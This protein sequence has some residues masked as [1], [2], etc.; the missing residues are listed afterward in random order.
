MKN[1]TTKNKTTETNDAQSALAELNA[2]IAELQSRRVTLAEPLK[3]RHAEMRT[4]LGD[5]ETQIRELDPTW[6][7]EPA[8]PKA[9]TKIAEIITAHGSPMSMD[10]IVVAVGNLFTAW[11]V[12]NTLK[13]KSSGVKALFALNDGKYG[14]KAAA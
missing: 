13:K 10:E 11:K 3:I 1:N 9:E 6:K 8:K 5:M 14:V 12:K 7:P 4:E 2:Q